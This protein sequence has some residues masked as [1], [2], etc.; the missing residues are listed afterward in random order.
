MEDYKLP[1]ILSKY[2]GKRDCGLFLDLG[3]YSIITENNAAQ[4]Y[5]DYAYIILCL[6]KRCIYTVI[7][8]YQIS[9]RP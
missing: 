6:Q 2:L 3:A 4:Y 5:P 9:S 7:Q 1:D 8:R